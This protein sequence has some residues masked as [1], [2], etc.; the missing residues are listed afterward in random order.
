MDD[1]S[2]VICLTLSVMVSLT[3]I[4]NTEEGGV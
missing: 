1:S 3:K 4:G 2:F